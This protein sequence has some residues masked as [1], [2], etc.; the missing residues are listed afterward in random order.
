MLAANKDRVAC[1]NKRSDGEGCEGFYYLYKG[2]KPSDIKGFCHRCNKEAKQKSSQVRID[3]N[4]NLNFKCQGACK[5]SYRLQKDKIY[6]AAGYCKKCFEAAGKNFIVE[7]ALLD[8][9]SSGKCTAITN[10]HLNSSALS[11][12]QSILKGPG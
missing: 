5:G 7:P 12:D 4:R 1:I 3:K 8:L 11:I 6:C 9:G 10:Q 2:K